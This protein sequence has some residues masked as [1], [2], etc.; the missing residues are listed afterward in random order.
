MRIGIGGWERGRRGQYGWYR[1]WWHQD[2]AEVWR[3]LRDEERGHLLTC[4]VDVV[5]DVRRELVPSLKVR[6][7]VLRDFK[8]IMKS[9]HER[10]SLR[11]YR[12]YLSKHLP[13]LVHL[14]LAAN[15]A[16]SQS[17]FLFVTSFNI[18]TQP[19]V[20]ILS[21]WKRSTLFQTSCL[22]QTRRGRIIIKSTVEEGNLLTFT[23]P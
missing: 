1:G 10:A 22:S 12:P 7:I 2:G 14:A 3:E 17:H 6:G 8:K 5:W 4:H 15:R 20:T 21:L 23:E 11:C 16:N 18:H 9:N 13:I 19:S